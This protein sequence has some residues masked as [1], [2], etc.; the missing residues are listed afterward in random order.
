M[1]EIE[2]RYYT[3]QIVNGWGEVIDN[4]NQRTY[5]NHP[6]GTFALCLDK[7]QVTLAAGTQRVEVA[8]K[9]SR[10]LIQIELGADPA[11]AVALQKQITM[12]TTG[13]PKIEAAVAA[14]D[15]ANDKL[16]GV[17]AFDTTDRDSRQR[18]GHQ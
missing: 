7:A 9:K 1:P 18:S 13:S 8:G 17:E 11:E 15:F 10:I 3:V 5:P 14:P 6:F 2:G 12:T 4:I 16:P